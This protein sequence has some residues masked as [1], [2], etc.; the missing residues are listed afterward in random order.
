[1]LSIT[2]LKTNAQ[3]F[4]FGFPSPNYEQRQSQQEKTEPAKYKGGRKGLNDFI[5]KN[6]RPVVSQEH[7][8]GTISIACIVN[9]KG[10][11]SETSVQ[12]GLSKELNAEA[13]RVIS[14]MK[15]KPAMQGKK[16][17]KSRIDLGFPIRHGKVSFSTLKTFD[18]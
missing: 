16:K 15:F 4:E 6:F 5:L 8:S 9:E 2:N 13:L 12:R 1:M 18:V 14:K 10:R 3:I 11:I 7:L 17:V